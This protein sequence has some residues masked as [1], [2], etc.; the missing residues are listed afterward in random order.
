MFIVT[1][2]NSSR[3]VHKF[4]GDKSSVLS[5]LPFSD[6]HTAQREL[7]CSS[8]LGVRRCEAQKL[9]LRLVGTASCRLLTE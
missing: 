6:P 3:C 1:V 2:D 4:E 5:H 9:L 7:L 8:C